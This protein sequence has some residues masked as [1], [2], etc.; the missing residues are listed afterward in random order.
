VTYL[1][2]E[3]GIGKS[4]WWVYVVALLT[5]AG[6]TVVIIITEDGW[7]D[8]VRP[9]MEAAGVD[10]DKVVML[11]VAE[12]PDDFEVGIPGPGWLAEQKLP[13]VALVVIDGLADATAHVNGGLPKATEWRPVITA[14]KRYA[15]RHHTAVLALGHTNRDT[16]NGTRGAVGLSGQIR[17]VV[18]LNLMALRT[19]DGQ[20]AIGVEKSNICR[21]DQPVDLFEI[22]EATSDGITVNIC[23]PCGIGDGTAKQMFETLAARS[24]VAEDDAEVELLDGCVADLVDLLGARQGNDSWALSTEIT[25]LLAKGKGT[26]GTRWTQGQINRARTSAVKGRHIETDHPKIPGPWFWRK[27]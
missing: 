19:D 12:E 9:R 1:F 25:D 20:L 16:L 17:Q 2:G 18:R 21:T 22:T 6:H 27:A 15:A 14:W 13:P 4:T 26:S 10:L 23:K 3:E 11:N 7:E 24:H 5:K 8:T